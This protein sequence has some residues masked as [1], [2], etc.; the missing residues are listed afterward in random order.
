MNRKAVRSWLWVD[1]ANSAFT[2]TIMATIMPIFYA[3][4]ATKHMDATTSTAFWGYTQSIALIVVV[5]LSPVLG[6]IADAA[7]SKKAFLCFFTFMGA[8]ASVLMFFIGEGD[9]IL[10]SV[11]M[12]IGTIGFSGS[13]SFYDAFLSDL[14]PNEHDRDLVSSIGYSFGYIGGGILLAINLLMIQYP[15]SFFL[16]DRLVATQVSFITVGLW[17]IGFS[18]PFFIHVKESKREGTQSR[19]VVNW[20]KHGFQSV[21]KTIRNIRRYPELL[22]FLVAFWF[23]SDGINTIIKMATIYGREVGIGQNDLIIALLLT[24]VVG[25]PFTI[26]FGKIAENFGAMR[27]LTMTLFVYLLIVMLGFFMTTSLHFYLLATAVGMVQGGSQ[28]LSRSLY[29]RL[30]PTKHQAEFFGFFSL[31]GKFASIFGPFVFG[32]IGQLMNSS[33][34]GII[35]IA[36]FF[37]IGIIILST[38][39]LEKGRIEAIT[40]NPKDDLYIA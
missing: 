6:A 12:I 16:P 15:E 18:I 22:K 5:L 17:W 4:V 23:F 21:G 34:L 2:T 30:V 9:W 10:A 13:N 27:T 28:A 3:D 32:L 38:I 20:T 19:S 8:I 25:I 11:L 33:R 39:N 24:Q 7:R 1:W 40:G 36:F 35:S 37:I 26:L 29:S 31:S 14:V